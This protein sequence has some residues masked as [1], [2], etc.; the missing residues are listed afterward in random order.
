[1]CRWDLLTASLMWVS[2]AISRGLQQATSV[3]IF[4][5]TAKFHQRETLQFTYESGSIIRADL[6][7]EGKGMPLYSM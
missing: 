4:P 7:N 2:G 6:G 3:D 5:W 1:M